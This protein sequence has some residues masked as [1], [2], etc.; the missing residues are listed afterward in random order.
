MIQNCIFLNYYLVKII[1][2]EIDKIVNNLQ[3][4]IILINFL[5]FKHS[6]LFYGTR[7]LT[8]YKKNEKKTHYIK[9]MKLL[10]YEIITISFLFHFTMLIV[11]PSYYICYIS[12]HQSV[13][14]TLACVLFS[15]CLVPVEVINK[16]LLAMDVPVGFFSTLWSF[17]T[18]LPFFFLLFLLG[19]LKG[20]LSHKHAYSWYKD[21]V[22]A[23][24]GLT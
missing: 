20:I 16:S 9:F 19:L 18:F 24:Q 3:N 6:L 4:I 2:L 12:R 17:I 15:L 7:I 13:N 22:C 8:F 1:F 21:F 5:S 23:E 14:Q 10:L 11:S